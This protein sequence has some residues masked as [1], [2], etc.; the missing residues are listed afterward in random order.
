M[1]VPTINTISPDSG[2]TM[3]GIGVFIDGTN[4]RL[5]TPILPAWGVALPAP[6]SVR[7]TF[8]DQVVP[9]EQTYVISTE[10]IGVKCPS[11]MLDI[12]ETSLPVDVI[13]ENIDDD[14]DAII[15]ESVTAVDGFTYSIPDLSHG[16]ESNLSRLSRRLL[17]LIQSHVMPNV[18][19]NEHPDYDRDTNTVY[20]DPAR[21]PVII[22]M[23]PAANKYTWY[24]L[25]Q[26]LLTPDN[27]GVL[28][29]ILA[30]SPGRSLALSWE[31]TGISDRFVELMN[32]AALWT[33]WAERT[34]FITFTDIYGQNVKLEL[35]IV[36]DPEIRG[37]SQ[38]QV[39]GGVRSW[40]ARIVIRGFQEG[41]IAGVTNDKTTGVTA[42]VEVDGVVLQPP[43]QL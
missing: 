17:N 13:V 31:V 12:D 26:D 9:W 42:P 36:S 33:S 34:K 21:L 11:Q 28:A 37:P 2:P 27:P 1:P 22:L 4:F 38:M 24:Q 40:S 18:V 25:T 41:W 23:G 29:P 20:V 39:N 15:G 16:N 19:M 43:I 30:Q 10:R 14:G 3:G 32:M 5:S 6:Q 35:D 8:G 7:V